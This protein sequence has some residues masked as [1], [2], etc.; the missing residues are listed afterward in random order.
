MRAMMLAQTGP[1]ESAPLKAVELEDPKPRRGE[2]SIRVSVCGVCRTDLHIVEGDLDL[3][4]LPIIPGH[5]IVGHIEAAGAGVDP[6]LIGSRVGVAWVNTTCGECGFCRTQRTNLCDNARFTGFSL[7]GGYAERV[8]VPASSTYRLPGAFDDEAVAPLLCAGII[9]YRALKM[10]GAR[11]S[12]RVGLYGFGGSA[13][14]ALQIAR[15]WGSEVYVATRS[16]AHQEQA[17]ALGAVWAGDA[18]D[19]EDHCL[20]AAVLFA[21]VGTLVPV[22]LKAL[23]KGATLAIAGIHLSPIPEIEYPLLYGERV[24]RSVANNTREDAEECLRL[25]A[26]IPIETGVESFKLEEANQ[27]LEAM[28]HSRL[29]APAAILRT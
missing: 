9:G 8:V 15:H 4:V 3:P 12:R 13:H 29:A 6:G 5:Q 11:S 27:A 14:I 21:P 2:V 17:K 16:A 25:G 7:N 10:S 23:R 20:D 22:I 26:E 24:I 1:I 19:V 18:R 28:K